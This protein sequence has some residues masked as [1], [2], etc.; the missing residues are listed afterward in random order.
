MPTEIQH[1]EGTFVP[2]AGAYNF[3]CDPPRNGLTLFHFSI[4]WT[5]SNPGVGQEILRDSLRTDKMICVRKDGNVYSGKIIMD[6]AIN[7]ADGAI[8]AQ[9]L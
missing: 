8:V 2:L 7:T 4:D 6:T 1:T 3:E 9:V 5:L